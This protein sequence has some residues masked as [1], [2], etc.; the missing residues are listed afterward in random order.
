[1]KR[2]GKILAILLL[3]GLLGTAAAVGIVLGTGYIRP[4]A[5][6]NVYSV[7]DIER[8]QLNLHF[9][10]VSAVPVTENYRVEVYV[11]AWLEYPLDFDEIMSVE[12]QDGTLSVT[13]TSFPAE[14]MGMFPQPYEMKMT[15]YLPAEAC[16]QIEEVRK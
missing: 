13:E 4:F 12:V 9:A 1:M 6:T 11:H 8:A 10:Q 2:A 3:I 7:E 16:R 5:E 14:F 15:L